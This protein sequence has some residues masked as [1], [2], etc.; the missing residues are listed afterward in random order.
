MFHGYIRQCP[1]LMP[2]G[3]RPNPVGQAGR[4]VGKRG[5][6]APPVNGVITTRLTPPGFSPSVFATDVTLIDVSAVIGNKRQYWD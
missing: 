6:R 3:Q 5:M 4:A 2:D 1:A